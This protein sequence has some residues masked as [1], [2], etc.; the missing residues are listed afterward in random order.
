MADGRV[1]VKDWYH[2]IVGGAVGA[3]FSNTPGTVGPARGF[4]V[5]LLDIIDA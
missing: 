3:L 1:R 2:G 4:D 5:P